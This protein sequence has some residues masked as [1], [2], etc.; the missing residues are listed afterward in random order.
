MNISKWRDK[1][2]CHKHDVI[3]NHKQIAHILPHGYPFLLVDK[4]IELDLENNRIIGQKNLSMNELFFQ[5]HF[6]DTPIMPGVLVL[7]ALAQ[8]AGILAHQKGFDQKIAV[9]LKIDNVKFRKPIYP[10]DILYLHVEGIYF[11]SK[12]ARVKAYATINA[13][14]E[15]PAVEAEIACALVERNSI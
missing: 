11:G 1:V 8:T 4:V 13:V 6:P 7:E 12:G 2:S 15:R 3:I 14:D 5:G 10:G 9:L